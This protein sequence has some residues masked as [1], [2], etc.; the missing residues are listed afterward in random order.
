[1]T[2]NNDSSGAIVFFNGVTKNIIRHTLLCDRHTFEKKNN[3]NP[4]AGFIIFL[5]N[6]YLVSRKQGRKV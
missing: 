3:R 5:P 4:L 1:M 6:F 2:H